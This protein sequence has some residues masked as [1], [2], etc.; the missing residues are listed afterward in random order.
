MGVNPI[1]WVRRLPIDDPPPELEYRRSRAWLAVVAVA[2]SLSSG[3]ALKS[4]F[5]AVQ[6]DLADSRYRR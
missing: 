5:Q 6:G 1:T 3:L 2:S 4:S